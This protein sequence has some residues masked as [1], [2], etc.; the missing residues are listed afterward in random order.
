MQ[1]LLFEDRF[2]MLVDAEYTIEREKT[3]FGSRI[4]LITVSGHPARFRN[5]HSLNDSVWCNPWFRMGYGNEIKR[6]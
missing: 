5:Y 4:N 1:E 6:P 2:G 3:L